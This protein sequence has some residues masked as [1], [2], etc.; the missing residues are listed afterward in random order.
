M[1]RSTYYI[2]KTNTKASRGTEAVVINLK[3]PAQ[4]TLE[5]QAHRNLSPIITFSRYV[6]KVE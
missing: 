4:P 5:K 2:I 3:L 6:Q 1:L